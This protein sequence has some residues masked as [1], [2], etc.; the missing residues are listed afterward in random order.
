[1]S[2]KLNFNEVKEINLKILEQYVPIVARVHG[3]SHPEFHEVHKVF[4]KI[5][6]KIK[7]VAMDKPDLEE[8][9]EQLRKITNNYAVPSDVCES[10]ETVYRLL[11]EL[12]KTYHA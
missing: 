3:E 2:K 10:Y 4:D 8:E 12:D 1:M 11:S 5:N 7:E 6:I 9:F